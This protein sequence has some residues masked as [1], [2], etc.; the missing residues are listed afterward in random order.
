MPAH[1]SP[2]ACLVICFFYPLAAITA[3][4]TCFRQI[5]FAG[6]LQGTKKCDLAEKWIDFM[7]SVPYQEDLPLNQFVYP[8]NPQARLPEAFTSG[9]RWR[10]S[11]P[12][13][14]P[15]RLPRIAIAGSRS[16][17]TRCCD[18]I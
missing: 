1:L 16:G 18:R 9:R 14:R 8:V 3:P 2:S 4:Q 11:Q 7:L 15:M 13:P 10:R 6:I 17:R 5:E 12:T